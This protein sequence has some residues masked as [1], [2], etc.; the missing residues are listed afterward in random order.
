MSGDGS[1]M[2]FGGQNWWGGPKDVVISKDLGDTWNKVSAPQYNWEYFA[3]SNDGSIIVGAPYNRHQTNDYISIYN[4]DSIKKDAIIAEYNAQ[5]KALTNANAQL[6]ESN[7]Q[8]KTLG[9]NN[10][11]IIAENN[12]QLKALAASNVYSSQIIAED[13]AKLS[14]LSQSNTQLSQANI[15]LKTA[16]ENNSQLK[17]MSETDANLIAEINAKL[18][19]LG[20]ANALMIAED[21]AKIRVLFET[22]SQLKT[23]ADA[24]SKIIEESNVK[25]NELIQANDKLKTVAEFNSQLKVAGETNTQLIAQTNAKLAALAETNAQIQAE[26]NAK[27][28]ALAEASAQIRT[29]SETNSQL[30]ILDETNKKIA[31]LAETNAQIQ[32]E[33]NA[34]IAALAETSAQIRTLSETNT[35]LRILSENNSELRISGETNAKIMAETN[36]KLRA[37]SETNTQLKIISEN[38]QQ[39]IDEDRSKLKILAETNIQLQAIADSLDA[40]K[41]KAP[42]TSEIRPEIR[43]EVLPP[44]NLCPKT[45]LSD[46]KYTDIQYIIGPDTGNQAYPECGKQFDTLAATNIKKGKGN[47]VFPTRALPNGLTYNQCNP[48]TLSDLQATAASWGPDNKVLSTPSKCSSSTGLFASKPISNNPASEGR[49]PSN[50]TPVPVSSNNVRTLCDKKVGSDWKY[51]DIQYIVGPA[52]GNQA[53]PECSKVHETLAATHFKKTGKNLVFSQRV[54]P[55]GLSYTQC[56]PST[57][58]DLQTTAA[59]WGPENIVATVP[60]NCGKNTGLV[61]PTPFFNNSPY[62]APLNK[63]TTTAPVIKTVTKTVSKTIPRKK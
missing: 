30:R 57:L 60:S 52:T 21:N 45:A 14:A 22:N 61:A 19:A 59:I 8:L 55:N 56:N 4:T 44:R 37:L 27:I 46:W 36:A 12:T 53:Y 42:T 38:N 1:T 11:R 20:D 34:K 2:I 18:K 13:N 7:I 5:I 6:S 15:Q 3:C 29:L 43:T 35:Q 26:T 47:L 62:I 23:L 49:L 41:Y 40:R 51:S 9:D 50:I 24:N 48:S 17:I 16:L 28:A 25:L 58:T 63:I 33:T 54:L 10:I 39:I 31:A 32:A